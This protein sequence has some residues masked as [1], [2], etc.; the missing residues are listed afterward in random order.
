MNS[1]N[2]PFTRMRRTR[3]KKY[4]RN[5]VKENSLTV[6]DFIY[7]V[8]IVDGTDKKEPIPEMPG[9]FRYSLDKLKKE[10]INIS[11]LNIPA[12][13]IFPNISNN[14]KNSSGSEAL[15]KN[16]IVCNAIKLIKD[17]NDEL[18]IVCDVALDPYTDHGHDG[19]IIDNYVDNDETVKILCEQA[20]IQTEAGCDIIAP[21]DMMDGRIR[22]IRETLENNNY[23]NTLIM[24]YT[25]KYYSSFY[26]PF[27]HA[28]GSSKNLGLRDKSTYQ[29][30]Y[31]NSK[32]AI[33]EA[34]LDISE[35]ADIII[36]KPGLPY[37]DIISKLNQKFDLPIFAYQ[38]SGEYSMIMTAINNGLLDK[39]VIIETLT[40]FKRAGCSG[41]LT[42]FA[43]IASKILNEDK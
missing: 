13:A 30:D 20:L 37:L 38:V 36:V 33:R 24:S 35:G 31:S 17:T 14:L 41:I 15:N 10:I 40:S 6:N 2:F 1:Y 3:A 43:P 22:K 18:G 39:S 27:R 21:S 9:L 5:L 25:A 16:N 11:N 19:V 12:I 4:I 8:F 23:K 34:N 32:E 26:G 29:M 7:P 42:Y 28:V